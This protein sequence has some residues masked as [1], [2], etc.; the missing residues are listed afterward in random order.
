M[1]TINGLIQPAF[2]SKYDTV[3]LSNVLTASKGYTIDLSNNPTTNNYI[4]F[5]DSP[6]QGAQIE[7]RSVAGSSPSSVKI[8]PFKPLDVLMGY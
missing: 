3:W 6:P 8:Y 4:K 5:A 2:Y 1:V 7:I